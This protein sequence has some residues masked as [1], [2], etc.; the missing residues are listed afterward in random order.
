MNLKSYPLR[1]AAFDGL[2]FTIPSALAMVILFVARA[3]RGADDYDRFYFRADLGATFIQDTMVKSTSP[4]S[5]SGKLPFDPGAR[6][7]FGFGCQFK[8]GLAAEFES[9]ISVNNTGS[10]ETE[11]G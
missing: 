4:Y 8:G 3:A 7:G 11:F 10:I 9:G 5:Q 1:R 2:P 6:L